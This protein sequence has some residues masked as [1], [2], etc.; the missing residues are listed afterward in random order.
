MRCSRDVVP[1][2]AIVTTKGFRDVYEL[3]RTSR[4]PMYDLKYRKPKDTSP[5]L[6]GI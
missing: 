4:D 5:A 1:K 6:S 2:V 3:G